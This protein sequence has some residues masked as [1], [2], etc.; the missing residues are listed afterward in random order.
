M[1]KQLEL[2]SSFMLISLLRAKFDSQ[3]IIRD[4]VLLVCVEGSGRCFF[5]LSEFSFFHAFVCCYVRWGS[6]FLVGY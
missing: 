3:S 4:D 5:W 1:Q 2:C 6:G